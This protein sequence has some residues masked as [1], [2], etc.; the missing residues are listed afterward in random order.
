MRD[1]NEIIHKPVAFILLVYLLHTGSFLTGY[2]DPHN[3]G[4]LH[5]SHLTL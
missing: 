1:N 5:S 3:F 2:T 4:S